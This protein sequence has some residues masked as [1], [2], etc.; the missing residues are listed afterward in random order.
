MENIP[1]CVGIEVVKQFDSCN[2]FIQPVDELTKTRVSQE[3]NTQHIITRECHSDTLT[4]ANNLTSETNNNETDQRIQPID[5]INLSEF[6]M[7]YL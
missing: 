2:Y 4:S 7:F 5:R 6:S 1:G 3:G